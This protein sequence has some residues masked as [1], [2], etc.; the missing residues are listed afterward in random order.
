MPVYNASKFLKEAL[1]SVVN[2][3]SKALKNI[4]IIGGS[5]DD[6]IEILEDCA[7]K[8]KY[9]KSFQYRVINIP[10]FSKKEMTHA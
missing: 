2:Q 9:G 6:S 10:I 5:T 7:A 1:D 3:T 8:Y 4:C